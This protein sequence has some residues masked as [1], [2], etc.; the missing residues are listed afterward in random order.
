M[1]EIATRRAQRTTIQ[2]ADGTRIMLN[3]D[4]RLRYPQSYGASSRD[5]YLDGEAYFEVSHNAQ[6]PFVVHTRSGLAEDIGTAF[7]VRA[8]AEDSSIRVVVTSGK[9]ALHATPSSPQQHPVTTAS[10]PILL[11]AGDLGRVR[12]DGAL[13][14]QHDVSTS[15]YIAFTEGRIAFDD[16]PVRDALR[17][18]AR[19]Y[20]LD[21]QLTDSASTR[22]RITASFRGESPE[23]VIAFIAFTLKAQYEQYGRTVVFSSQP[24]NH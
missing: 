16:V 21:F 6:K 11:S 5:V 18:L 9:V 13:A 2:L 4:S 17:Q 14:V 10:A 7:V 8:Y 24:H 3:V 20:D 15:P 23:K 19:W 1:N 12:T 22:H